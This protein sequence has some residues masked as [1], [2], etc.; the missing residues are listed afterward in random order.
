MV[1]CSPFTVMLAPEAVHQFV[2][3]DVG[4]EWA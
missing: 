4:E 1:V 2:G 3:E